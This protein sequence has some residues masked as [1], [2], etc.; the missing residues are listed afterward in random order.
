MTVTVRSSYDAGAN[1][2]SN[3]KSAAEIA[4]EIEH[5]RYRLDSDMRALTSRLSAPIRV[6]TV[7]AALA[8][9]LVTYLIRRSYRR[10]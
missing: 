5:T 9:T 7:V 8:V 2:R 1:W 3:G 4:D 10:R 6:V